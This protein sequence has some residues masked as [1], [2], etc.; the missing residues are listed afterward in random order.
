MLRKSKTHTSSQ[1]TLINF[2]SYIYRI[3]LF[4]E[5]N[6][7]MHTLLTHLKKAGLNTFFFGLMLMILLA[8]LFPLY[9]IKGS[10]LRLHLITTYGVGLIFFFYGLRLSPEKF[11]TGL[12]NW[13]LHLV[14]QSI[15]FLLFPAVALSGYYLIGHHEQTFL[16][17]GIFYL[18]ALPSTVS[19]SVVMVSIGGGNLAG[20]IFNASVSSILGIFTTPVLISWFAG[21]TGD[22][23]DLQL[24]IT[25]LCF[26]VL[27]PVAAG[28]L[29]HNKLGYWAEKHK[30]PLRWF[31]QS[32][33]LL[34]VYT[35]FCESFT[36]QLFERY[37]AGEILSFIVIIL[38][39]LIF[40]F[41]LV[42]M[43]G[44]L[45]NFPREDRITILFCGS[46]KSLVQGAVM[47]KVLFPVTETLGIV[48]LPVMVYHTLQL[49]AGSVIA[50]RMSRTES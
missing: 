35:A 34:I 12:A 24:V 21:Q 40:M 11:R 45:L 27:L 43:I 41:F 33:I 2:P 42:N 48:L 19:S 30:V 6:L 20:A 31:D 25:K 17:L 7:C 47:G 14:I 32:I 50:E 28:L 36:G 10:P 23:I 9:G 16:W 37:T 3:Q 13:R 1:A 44:L 5:Y 26:Q 29:L 38:V 4:T 8:W 15:T 46:K 39:F 49:I 18:A 22:A